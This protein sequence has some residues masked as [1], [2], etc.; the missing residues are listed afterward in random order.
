MQPFKQLFPSLFHR[1]IVIGMLVTMSG[2]HFVP[3][4]SQL[5]MMLRLTMLIGYQGRCLF[6]I[7]F[8][9]L[10]QIAVQLTANGKG[11]PV[12]ILIAKLT[13]ISVSQIP[14]WKSFRDFCLC[15]NNALS[16]RLTYLKE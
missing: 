4:S 13:S 10:F 2:F 5:S 6:S 11:V 7:Q 16:A 9:L 1:D 15:S 14:D 3:F 8:E 12:L